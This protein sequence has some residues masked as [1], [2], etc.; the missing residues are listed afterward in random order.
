MAQYKENNNGRQVLDIN[1]LRQLGMKRISELSGSLWT[2]YNPTDPGITLHE[3][4][5][6][7]V[8]DLGYRMTFDIPD[9]LT[10]EG[11]H[12]PS[13]EYSFHEPYKALSS[14]PITIDDYRKLILEN[15]AGVKNVWLTPT[16]RKVYLPEDILSEAQG[17]D[18]ECKS[19]DLKGY[20]DVFV[21]LVDNTPSSAEAA[22]Q[23]VDRLLMKHRNLC[24]NFLP[25]QSMEHIPVGIEADIEVESDYNYDALLSTLLDE[26][27]QYI[28]TSLHL[29]SFTE[30]LEKGYSVSDIFTGPLPRLGYVDMNEI[31]PL[32]TN[33]KLYASDIINIIMQHSGVKG[34][35]HLAFVV[36]EEN[37]REV[38]NM[39]YELSLQDDVITKKSFRFSQDPRLSQF[40]FMLD[41]YQF[42]AKIP[43]NDANVHSTAGQSPFVCRFEEETSKNH[44]YDRYYTIQDDFPSIYLVGRENISDTEDDLRKA[45]RMQ[46]KG[47]LL[48][49][50]QLLADFL[51]RINSARHLLSWEKYSHF[52]DWK[53]HQLGYMHRVL[54]GSD[55]DDF[56][57]IVEKKTYGDWYEKHIFDAQGELKQR[58]M[59]LNHLLA[60]FNEDFVKYSVLQYIA[61][62]DEGHDVTRR[63]YEQMDSKTDLLRYLPYLGYHRARAIDYTQ[64]LTLDP[65]YKGEDFNDGNY[66]AI[67]RKLSV[68]FGVKNYHPARHLHPKVI[69]TKENIIEFEDNREVDYAETFGIHLYEH[70]LY[71]PV[72]KET[73]P[74]LRQYRSENEHEY[75]EDP[76]SMKVTAVLPGWLNV[77]QNY[78]FRE[79][80]E[81]SIQEMFPAHIAVKICWIGPR[82]MMDIENQHDDVLK[83]MERGYS[84][85]GHLTAF[86]QTLSH[87]KNMYQSAKMTSEKEVSTNRYSRLDYTTLEPHDYYWAKKQ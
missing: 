29:Y 34:V 56:E 13:H 44:K 68:A 7:S 84:D 25:C 8:L 80:V 38:V 3:I 27:S 72:E 54:T 21:D 75:V 48:F 83:D 5:C 64:P 49:F 82:Q 12:Y 70:C 43:E 77:T 47:Y 55:I 57:K 36:K 35:R 24:E 85:I 10:P 16:T 33:H 69:Q 50:D 26:I 59:A 52:D 14:G 39:N 86:V 76:Y 63:E 66:Y 61:Q 60:R 37:L 28:S 81:K 46:F 17:I 9:L 23:E 78:Q 42:T 45:Q 11:Y 71:A 1:A 73:E 79:L 18:S 22:K 19:I 30:M 2:D 40:T 87:L 15:V 65:N 32:D 41:N 31:E 4:L 20:Y 53:E 58:N 67:E 74:F 51:M 62:E 6:F